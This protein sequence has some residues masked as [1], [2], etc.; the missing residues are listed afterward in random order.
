MDQNGTQYEPLG[1][2]CKKGVCGLCCVEIVEGAACIQPV[3]E[4]SKELKTIQIAVGVEPNP[5]KYRLA[6]LSRIQGPVKLRVPE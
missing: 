6:C 5:A 1:S 4:S 2:E 3:D